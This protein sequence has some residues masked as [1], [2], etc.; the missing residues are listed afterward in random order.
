MISQGQIV[1]PVLSGLSVFRVISGME[2]TPASKAVDYIK[3]N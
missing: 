3:R 2:K 1:L